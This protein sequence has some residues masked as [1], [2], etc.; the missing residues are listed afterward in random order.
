MVQASGL[1]N[2]PRLKKFRIEY[3]SGRIQ[4][5]NGSSFATTGRIIN[6]R[7]Y[8][9]RNLEE[10]ARIR[11]RLPGALA[12]PRQILVFIKFLFANHFFRVFVLNSQRIKKVIDRSVTLQLHNFGS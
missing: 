2:M 7:D 3:K 11:S 10:N 8:Y 6:Y 4:I 5:I 12:F 1:L 9:R